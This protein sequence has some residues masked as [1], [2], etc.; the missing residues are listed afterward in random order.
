MNMNFKYFQ[1][2]ALQQ[3]QHISTIFILQK[4]RPSGRLLQEF[5][6]S[7]LFV[8]PGSLETRIQRSDV[9]SVAYRSCH[10]GDYGRSME[11]YVLTHGNT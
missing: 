2:S 8:C 4:R 6:H 10:M 9:T 11:I 3:F 1:I 5:F 7:S